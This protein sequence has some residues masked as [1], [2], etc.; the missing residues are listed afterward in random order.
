MMCQPSK[1]IVGTNEITLLPLSINI[2]PM[3]ELI[4]T[5]GMVLL[6][7]HAYLVNTLAI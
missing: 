4:K 6:P 5:H 1:H 7:Y 2:C 3:L